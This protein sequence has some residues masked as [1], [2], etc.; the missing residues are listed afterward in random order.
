MEHQQQH[1]GYLLDLPMGQGKTAAHFT[2][3]MLWQLLKFRGT[4]QTRL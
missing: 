3:M 1:L 4:Y 2:P